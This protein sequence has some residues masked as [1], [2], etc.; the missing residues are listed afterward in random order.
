MCNRFATTGLRGSVIAAL[1]L[2]ATQLPA[3]DID[4]A[5]RL[6]MTGEYDAALQ[7]AAEAVAANSY[8]ED[9]WLLKAEME[10]TLGR[11]ADAKDTLV[12]ALE[13]Y[14]WSIRVRARLRDASR[15]AGDDELAAA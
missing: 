13:K 14:Q 3:A 5:R 9:W 1:W 2:I 8:G 6:A 15:F 12:A 4:E 7:T 11:Y 10:Q